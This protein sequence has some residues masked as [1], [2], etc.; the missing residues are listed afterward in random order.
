MT[1][2]RFRAYRVFFFL[3]GPFLEGLG[4]RLLGRTLTWVLSCDLF[5]KGRGKPSDTSELRS[6]WLSAVALSTRPKLCWTSL[7]ASG[8]PTIGALIV[9]IGFRGPVY[10]IIILRNPQNSIGSYLLI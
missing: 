7:F 1:F 3:D 9:R 10:Y 4:F 5:V 2:L 8:L 6:C